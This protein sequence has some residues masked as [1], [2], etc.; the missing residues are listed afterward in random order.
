M[1][2]HKVKDKLARRRNSYVETEKRVSK[3]SPKRAGGYKRPGSLSQR[4]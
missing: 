1:K 2:A 3:V 4:K